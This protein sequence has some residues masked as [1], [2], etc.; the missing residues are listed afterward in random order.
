MP[1]LVVVK[2]AAGGKRPDRQPS[3]HELVTTGIH[4]V[5]GRSVVLDTVVELD[6]I[7][8]SPGPF[9]VPLES[10]DTSENKSYYP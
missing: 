4:T 3:N 2:I 1:I 5:D 8:Q 7:G 10:K 6:H 9:R